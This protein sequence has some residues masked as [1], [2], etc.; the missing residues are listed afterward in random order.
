M[1]TL[2]ADPAGVAQPTRAASAVVENR[3]RAKDVVLNI[4]GHLGAALGIEVIEQ[5]ANRNAA[6]PR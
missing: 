3:G 4:E 1:F 6:D 2:L 5:R